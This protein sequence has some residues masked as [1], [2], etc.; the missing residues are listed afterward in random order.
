MRQKIPS[1]YDYNDFRRFIADYQAARRELDP[2]YTKSLMSKLLG[3]PN[4]RSYMTFILQGKKVST[5]FVDRFVKLF[6]FNRDEAIFFRVLVKFNQAESPGERELYFEQL[7]G[8]NKDRSTDRSGIQ[9]RRIWE[10][11]PLIQ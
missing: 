6:A 1:I 3:L 11:P 8:L 10:G 2:A 9:L 5:T 7:I 4:S